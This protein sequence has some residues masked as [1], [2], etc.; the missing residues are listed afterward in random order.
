MNDDFGYMNH[1]GGRGRPGSSGSARTSDLG[2]GNGFGGFATST[3]DAYSKPS[4][5]SGGGGRSTAFATPGGG[6]RD[7]PARRPGMSSMGSNSLTPGGQWAPPTSAAGGGAGK[8]PPS[9]DDGGGGGGPRHRNPQGPP[10]GGNQGFP[11]QQQQQPHYNNNYEQQGSYSVSGVPMTPRRDARTQPPHM[12]ARPGMTPQPQRRQRPGPPPDYSLDEEDDA[13]SQQPDYATP[14]APGPPPPP[15]TPA[16]RTQPPGAPALRHPYQQPQQQYDVTA[17]A[18][19]A[20]PPAL[21]SASDSEVLALRA[22]VQQLAEDLSASSMQFYG[23]V[24][25]GSHENV[26][27]YDVIPDN[28]AVTKP[29]CRSSRGKWLKLSYPRRLIQRTTI[30]QKL[31]STTWVRAY[32]IRE[33]TGEMMQYWVN[34]TAQDGSPAFYKFMVYPANAEQPAPA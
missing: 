22:Q 19:A 21:S 5:Q 13:S 9:Y 6:L 4:H 23:L 25:G 16:R 1:K 15:A 30:D 11:R 33:E 7:N 29:Q 3:T 24:A 32:A 17:A 27:L 10:R 18:A 2:L 28:D 26:F 31:A 12:M 8:Y 34:M 20:P 14:Y